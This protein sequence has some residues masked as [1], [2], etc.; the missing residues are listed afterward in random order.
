MAKKILGIE[1][2]SRK[3]LIAGGITVVLVGTGFLIYRKWRNK[4]LVIALNN[5]LEN[6]TNQYGDIRD[7]GDVF[8]GDT[9][10]NKV[11]DIAKK[12][13]YAI[14]KLNREAITKRRKQMDD[15]ITGFT[16]DEDKIYGIFNDLRDKVAI[17]Q[18]AQSYKDSNK[19]LTLLAE[20]T[21]VLNKDEIQKVTDI[22]SEKAAFTKVA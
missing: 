8:S 18:I 5:V 17:A 21:K 2:N 9:Y 1:W 19:G 4:Q 10:I 6:R 15:A 13:G 16:E 12:N 3:V 14:I 7:F 22:V 11:E 20:L